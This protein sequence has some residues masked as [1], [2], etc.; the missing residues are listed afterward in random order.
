MRL[1]SNVK[2]TVMHFLMQ[3]DLLITYGGRKRGGGK[4]LTE[5]GAAVDFGKISSSDTS[6]NHS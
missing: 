3:H 4:L 6:D 5:M 1:S 2:L